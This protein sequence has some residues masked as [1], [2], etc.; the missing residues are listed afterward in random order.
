MAD[1]HG[2]AVPIGPSVSVMCHVEHIALGPVL[3]WDYSI[4]GLGLALEL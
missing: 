2:Q 1:R 3:G 4:P